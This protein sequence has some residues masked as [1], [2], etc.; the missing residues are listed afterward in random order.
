MNGLMAN[1]AN[2]NYVKPMLW[3]IAVMVMVFMLFYQKAISTIRAS[4]GMPI[5]VI[6]KK[7]QVFWAIIIF[8][9]IFVVNLLIRFKVTP[10]FLFHYK[11]MFKNIAIIGLWMRWVLNTNITMAYI[12]TTFPFVMIF[13]RRGIM[14]FFEL[15]VR[16][17][18]YAF[19]A[20]CNAFARTILGIGSTR[21]NVKRFTTIFANTRFKMFNFVSMSF[22]C[23]LTHYLIPYSVVIKIASCY[24]PFLA[25]LI[26]SSQT[27]LS[28]SF[29]RNFQ[30]Q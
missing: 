12:S 10:K 4:F 14:S 1:N 3:L 20:C 26:L 21:E 11:A 25:R 2:R 8:Y 27:N 17:T 19:S 5:F 15:C 22:C 9:T 16:G 23:N 29:W 6:Y 18:T 28:T 30:W 7:L 13:S 24:N